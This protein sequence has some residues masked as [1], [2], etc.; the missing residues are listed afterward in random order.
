MGRKAKFTEPGYQKKGPGRKA[1][2]QKEPEIPKT[3]GVE[4][5][6]QLGRR[7]LARKRRRNTIER[8]KA[9]AAEAHRIQSQEK[10]ELKNR[11]IKEELAAKA[12]NAA[13][14]LK[15][16]QTPIAPAQK[17]RKYHSSSEEEESA[18]DEEEEEEEESDDSDDEGNNVV[19]FTDDNSSWLKPVS[20]KG[21][22]VTKTPKEEVSDDEG[23]S[24]DE[25]VESEGDS[26]DDDND[27]ES[28]ADSDDEED[29]AEADT[30]VEEEESE[31]DSDEMEVESSDSEDGETSITVPDKKKSGKGESVT[32][33]SLDMDSDDSD[34]DD[35]FGGGSDDDSDKDS[36]D[37]SDNESDKGGDS[38]KSDDADMLPIEK[39][40][41]KLKKKQ[42][43]DDKL[44][45][46]EL[47]LNV[48][49]QDVFAFPSEE[50][51]KK[52]QDLQDVQ[53][54]IKDVITVL[55][56]FKRLHEPGRARSEYTDLLRQ[57]LCT[58]YSYNEFLMEKLMQVFQLS[59]LLEF[60]EASET[61][62]PLTIRV[63][64]LKARR[65]DVAQAL[66]NRGVNL[67]PLGEW[68]KVGLVIYSSQVPIGATP[69]YLAGQYIIQGAS[70]L[71]PVMA[72]APQEK[73]RILDMA[74][75]PGGKA[76]HIAAVMK[77]TGVL[78]ANDANRDRTKAIVGNF[79]RLGVV[80]SVITCYDG[81]K[82]TNVLKGFDRVL[83]DAPCT[84][85][86][87]VSKDPSVKS[88][89]DEIDIQRC[90]TLQRELLLAAID[91]LNARSSTGGY[92]VYS[93]CSVLVEENE[94]VIDYALRKR[95]VR[96]VPT[97]LNFGAEGFTRFRHLRFHPSLNLTRR[98]YPHTHNMDGF[99]VAKLQKITNSVPKSLNPDGNEEENPEES[100]TY[101]ADEIVKET[102]ETDAK[103]TSKTPKGKGNKKKKAKMIAKKKEM[104][105]NGELERPKGRKSK[106]NVNA[107]SVQ[108]SP[109][110]KEKTEGISKQKPTK[111]VNGTAKSAT[112]ES[113]M[114][115]GSFANGVA[116]KGKKKNSA[117]AS[118]S[119]P[120]KKKARK[121]S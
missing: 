4:V 99:F 3:L 27:E 53:Q 71:L 2:K 25:E 43:R 83:L 42:K 13:L 20:K 54:R 72:L 97:G 120:P 77:N 78:F 82:I 92:L 90:C 115:K 52:P 64:S 1:K 66:I 32:V 5:D 107:K 47:Q 81:R 104:R 28:E 100:G 56:D 29:D 8:E 24:D 84:G 49:N 36:E 23:D 50:E 16:F 117:P 89:K 46:E 94:W 80:N 85:T 60:L 33:Q 68:T 35:D 51:I 73:E 105:S 55:N 108:P 15:E 91:S 79:H 61:Q 40:A 11:Q 111:K 12:K 63:N 114:K 101:L 70:S 121:S 34:E 44:A 110:S 18:E 118:G 116:S 109:E 39:Q 67:D 57:D 41:K 88:N 65:K 19:G 69:E 74:A 62:R 45:E 93:T 48:A 14:K 86:G 102:T 30:D 98:F 9:E 59:E 119:K 75:A 6:K 112:P 10:R 87:V 103:N 7:S 17:R 38:D 96:L 58:Y 113:N 37:D 21:A 95:A 26:D 31:A 106:V 22:K 76:S